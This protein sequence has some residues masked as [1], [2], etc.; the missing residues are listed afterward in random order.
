MLMAVQH[1][2]AFNFIAV[3]LVILAI[4]LP[5]CKRT[6]AII[7]CVYLFAVL[8]ARILFVMPFMADVVHRL[9]TILETN[10][11]VS[12]LQANETNTLFEWIGFKSG[13]KRGTLGPY[14]WSDVLVSQSPVGGPSDNPH[15]FSSF[16]ESSFWPASNS[17]SSTDNVTDAQNTTFPNHPPESYLPR[18]LMRLSSTRAS[19]PD[20]KCSA[21]IASTNLDWSSLSYVWS[22]WRGGGWTLWPPY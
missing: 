6:S 8:V 15:I 4:L 17:P 16:L 11:N 3:V 22:M 21:T 5:S 9:N 14:F 7:I 19:L 20:S 13:P 2:C 18:Q 10:C 1:F 12:V